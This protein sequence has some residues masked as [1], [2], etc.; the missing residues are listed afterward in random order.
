MKGYIKRLSQDIKKLDA[1]MQ[2]VVAFKEAPREPID[3]KQYEMLCKQ[4]ELMEQLR[5]LMEQRLCYER[6]VH[7]DYF[8]DIEY[9]EVD[10]VEDYE[11]S[12]DEEATE[13]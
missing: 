8:E 12:D 6:I 13:E 4:A 9:V 7:P 5:N 11:D 2:A 10:N 1:K 3:N